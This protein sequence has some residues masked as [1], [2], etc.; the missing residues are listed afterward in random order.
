MAHEKFEESQAIS[1]RSV[2]NHAPTHESSAHTSR[3]KSRSASLGRFYITW[4]RSLRLSLFEK[5]ILANS[6]M[7]VG[8]ALAGLWVTSHN[9]ESRHYLIDTTFIVLAALFSLLVNMLLLRASFRPLFNLLHTMRAVSSGETDKRVPVT[10]SDS[11]IGELAQAF[12]SMLDRLEA[13]RREQAML[14]LQAQ[15]EERRRLALELHDESSQ[16]LT[17]VLVHTEVLSQSLQAIPSRM[18]TTDVRVQLDEGLK[19]LASLTQHTL[20]NIRTLAQQLRP[21]VLDDLGLHA[22][23]RWL[24][25]DAHQRLQLAVELRIDGVEDTSRTR[26]A[27]APAHPALYETALFR[28]AQEGLTNVARH[29]HAQR[30]FISLTQDQ[31]HI[32]LQ[33]SDDGC[34]YDPAQSQ[35]GLGIFGMRE[36]AALLGGTVTIE[37]RSGEGTLVRAVLP[38]PT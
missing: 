19:Y 18:I 36:R 21:S 6:L 11:E 7:L 8:E 1:G 9:I 10:A 12:N 26:H 22:A 30:V 32:C 31:E 33:V 14:I 13:A 4:I 2:I 35:Q 16:N 23:F 25:E 27:G 3:G 28:I 24:A 29:A 34:G 15:D 17:A 37:S 5:V 38:L 20:D